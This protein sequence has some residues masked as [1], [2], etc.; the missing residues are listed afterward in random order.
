MRARFQAATAAVTLLL[1]CGDAQSADAPGNDPAEAP[2]AAEAPE[3]PRIE[4]S[5][6]GVTVINRGDDVLDPLTFREVGAVGGMADE[7]VQWERVQRSDLA[8]VDG[9]L[10][11]VDRSGHRVDVFDAAGD[12][13]HAFGSR[14]GGPGELLMPGSVTDLNGQIGI[15][16]YGR[17]GVVRFTVDGG[18]EGVWELDHPPTDGR[19]AATADALLLVEGIGY[20]EE[21]DSVR[22]EFVRLTTAGDRDV[23]ASIRKARP[24]MHRFPGCVSVELEPIFD[25]TVVWAATQGRIA[26]STATQYAIEL[27]S[28]GDPRI[29]TREVEPRQMSERD[30]LAELRDL[31][32]TTPGLRC[33]ITAEDQAKVRGFESE[34]QTV[35]EMAFRPGGELW[36][37]R[38]HLTGEEPLIDRFDVEGT[39][40]GTR[41]GGP[42]PAV[43]L[44]HDMFAAID[45]D[46]MEVPIVRIFRIES[47]R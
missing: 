8:V 5:A 16:D 13:V 1:G 40:Q 18:W 3:F 44:S 17:R 7:R 45:Q 12:R 32:V 38:G 35:R 15:F 27:R 14:G 47:S 24:G 33:T 9:H 28:D 2:T 43:F 25:R 22:E 42:F 41:T 31:T 19:V 10:V 34:L 4:R 23:I 11:I 37:M 30:A 6:N 26:T 29:V 21:G 46:E 39:Y 20:R 36:V